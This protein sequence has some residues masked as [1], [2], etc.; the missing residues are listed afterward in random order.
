ML[1]PRPT[2]RIEIQN[3]P[4]DDTI[5]L[6]KTYL[7][8]TKK[9]NFSK[10]GNK[11]SNCKDFHNF[12]V[13]LWMLLISKNSNIKAMIKYICHYVFFDVLIYA[14]VKTL[15]AISEDEL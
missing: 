4:Q 3:Q 5:K 10:T 1:T 9:I 7:K 14:D 2:S 8:H 13:N 6:S 15:C 11:L 12:F